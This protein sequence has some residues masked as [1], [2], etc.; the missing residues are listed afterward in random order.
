MGLHLIGRRMRE[1][2]PTRERLA[3]EEGFGGPR[4]EIDGESYA[5]AGKR[6]DDGGVGKAGMRAENRFPVFGEKHGAAPPMS[7][8]N[9]AQRGMQA[10]DAA[11]DA[12]NAR[13]D[14]RKSICHGGTPL[15]GS[16]H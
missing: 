5:M 13:G 15:F 8:F 6:A 4:A 12:G 16:G 3:A 9:G 1:T 2:L 7:E 14:G 11:L 10:A